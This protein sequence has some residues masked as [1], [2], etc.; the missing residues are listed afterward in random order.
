MTTLDFRN[1]IIG[2][3]LWTINFYREQLKYFA[4][5][6]LGNRTHHDVKVTKELIAVT[7]K[8]LEQLST[9]YD[10]SLTA[11]GLRHRK[12]KATRSVLNGQT[13]NG[14]GATASSRMQDNGNPRHE[15]DKT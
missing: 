6:G 15:R 14:N 12:R 11:D 7:E 5:V 13:T 3:R 4:K 2:S 8:R 9:I 10:S 1:D